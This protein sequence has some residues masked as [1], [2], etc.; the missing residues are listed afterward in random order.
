[1]RETAN[2]TRAQQ[3][4]AKAPAP[5]GGQPVRVRGPVA[6][7][8]D[9]VVILV[10]G[11]NATPE[12]ILGLADAVGDE[13][14]SYLAPAAAGHTWYPFSFLTEIPRNEPG[15]TSGLAVL[16]ALVAD[17]EQRG[18]PRSRIV[19]GGFSQ[20][21]CLT[22]EFAVRN[23][24]R[25]GGVLVY[26]GGVIGPPGTTWSYPGSFDGT[27]VLL[28]C[29]DVDPHIPLARV[30]ETAEVFRRMGAEV[31]KRIY[32]GMGHFVNEDEIAFTKEL[33]SKVGRS[34]GG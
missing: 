17:L 21:G 16:A 6:E 8:A 4:S 18:V 24:G 31:D 34:P 23:A 30:N 33:L 26:S 5:H 9:A 32:P 10:H 27:P 2:D 11:R 19:I 13:R 15:I 29:S 1:M 3:A 14:V 7:E 22:S 12:D 28:G 25:F 20:G